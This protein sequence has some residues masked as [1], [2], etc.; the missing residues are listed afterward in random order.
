MN[1]DAAPLYQ[2]MLNNNVR[3]IGNFFHPDAAGHVVCELDN[4]LR[5]RHLGEIDQN[6]TY[7]L[8]ANNSMLP[9]YMSVIYP[10]LFAIAGTWPPPVDPNGPIQFVLDDG[11]AKMAR[12]IH[13]FRPD[14]FVD[15]GVSGLK[16]VLEDAKLRPQAGIIAVSD[17]GEVFWNVSNDMDSVI[18]LN[19]LRRRWESRD[20]APLAQVPTMVPELQE[21]LG[22]DISKLAVIHIRYKRAMTNAGTLTDPAVLLPTLGYLRDNGYK[23]VKT[24]TEPYPEEFAEYGVINYSES[25]WRN[26]ANDITLFRAAKFA[27]INASGIEYLPELM[28]IPMVDYGRWQMGVLHSSPN[29]VVIP[30]M[31]RRK[32]NG[33]L[34]KFMEQIQYFKYQPEPWIRGGGTHFPTAD[35]EERPPQADELLAASIEAIALGENHTP[36][37]ELQEE[38]MRL[39]P[40]I[41]AHCESRVSQFF[42]ER[43]PDSVLSGFVE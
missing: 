6:C 32:S 11:I 23:I 7:V 28:R 1:V 38:F 43:F 14:L 4:F 17:W 35:F 40:K 5:M 20:Y 37:S 18:Q 19:Y 27:M 42:L 25:P 29:M 31:M 33:R 16:V 34:M 2:F 26:F 41:L 36:R 13:R 22:G 30:S 21:F 10:H 15:V 24:G 3:G 9:R 39:E 8:F 12:S